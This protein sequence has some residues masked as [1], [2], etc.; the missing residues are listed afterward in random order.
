M[1]YHWLSGRDIDKQA[2]V[3]MDAGTLMQPMLLD[4]ARHDLN[5][6]IEPAQT[7]VKKG[8][9][10]STKDAKI[11]DP[12]RGPGTLE[13][14]ACFD[15]RQWMTQ[16]GGGDSPPRQR[17]PRSPMF[18]GD[19]EGSEPYKWGVIAVWLAGEM[20]DFERAA[21]QV[22]GRTESGRGQHVRDGRGGQGQSPLAI[23]SRCPS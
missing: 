10:G 2:D 14:K 9:L 1:L 8:Q 23:L 22:V 13:T 15:Y 21:A 11:F 6:S 3:R 16:W 18:V 7:Y 19:G 20:R 17:R 4:L 12:N 5:L